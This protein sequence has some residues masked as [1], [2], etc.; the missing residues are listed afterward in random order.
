[1]R[2]FVQRQRLTLLTQK[3]KLFFKYIYLA[4]LNIQTQ[5]V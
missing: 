1:M 5:I 2:Y 4:Y 3:L